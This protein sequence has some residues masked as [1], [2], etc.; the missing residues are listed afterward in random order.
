VG[1]GDHLV[2]DIGKGDETVEQVVA[3]GAS[4]D[5]VQ[6]K[7]DLGRGEGGDCLAR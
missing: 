5:D 4:A 2:A 7:V 3:V 1:A 6:V